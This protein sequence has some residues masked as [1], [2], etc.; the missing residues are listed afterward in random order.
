MFAIIGWI[1]LVWLFLYALFFLFGV[2]AD[3]EEGC[4]AVQDA[5]LLGRRLKEI[6]WYIRE[7]D[8]HG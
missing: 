3:W 7:G 6:R 5:F 1:A 4:A 2:M 8:L